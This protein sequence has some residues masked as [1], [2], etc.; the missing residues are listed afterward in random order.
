MPGNRLQNALQHFLIEL[1]GQPAGRLFAM[2]GGGVQADVITMAAGPISVHKHIG[3]LKYE[4]MTLTFGTSMAQAFY[5]WISDSIGGG[6][7]RKSGAIV[8]LSSSG[9]P[10][11]RL[12]FNNALIHSLEMPACDAGSKDPAHITIMISPE[13]TRSISTDLKHN[14]GVYAS[15][16]AKGWYIHD[17]KLSIDGLDCTHVR[18]IEALRVGKKITFD[19]VANIRDEVL[20]E[21]PEEYSDLVVTLNS[22]HASGFLKWFEEFVEKGRNSPTDEKNGVLHFF[23]PNASKAYFKMELLGL[24]LYKM[25]GAK[26]VNPNIAMPLTFRL[27]C[28]EMKF[29]AGPAAMT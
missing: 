25:E 5:N 24:G 14:T 21:G 2:S 18:S 29:S 11:W 1:D 12:E 23:A 6:S 28:N 19:A 27:Y 15:G 10:D 8:L 20:D 17:F 3:A 26:S 13:S 7:K 22:N 16:L 9:K 4:D